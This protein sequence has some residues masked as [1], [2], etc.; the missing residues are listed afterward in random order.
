MS[1][2]PGSTVQIVDDPV[3]GASAQATD[4]LYLLSPYGPD[5]AAVYTSANSG[6]ATLDAQLTAYFKD[7][8]SGRT[9]VGG[10][11]AVVQ[12]Y[13][14][15]YAL[16]ELDDALLLLPSGPGQVV[17]PHVVDEPEMLLVAEGAWAQNKVALLNSA[18]GL[19]DSQV[20]VLAA[21]L[22]AGGDCRGAGLWCDYAQHPAAGG[23]TVT[24]PFTVTVAAM[25]AANDIALKNPGIA[26]AGVGGISDD[27]VSVSDLRTDTRRE[28][29]WHAQVNTAKVVDG[30]IRNYG[31]RTLADLTTLPQWAFFSGSRVVM[32]L[33]EKAAEL[34]ETLV[35]GQIDGLGKFLGR[36][37]GL[38]RGACKDLYDIKALFG[39]TPEDAYSVDVGPNV[40]PLSNL[41]AGLVTAQVRLKTS[42]E[43]EHIVTN[44][45]VRAITQSV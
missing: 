36:Y 43:A 21:A 4:T 40:N 8:L 17:A 29:L 39:D 16:P 35:F 10:K 34:D 7:G 19:T 24:V 33:C 11:T 12:G 31:Y 5:E 18:P 41:Q 26:A 9:V 45:T 23:T 1:P 37:E 38:L 13:G 30:K 44:I 2:V 32:A 25:I 3:S 28:S 22:I 42:T 27:V 14:S 15:G 6:N 20:S